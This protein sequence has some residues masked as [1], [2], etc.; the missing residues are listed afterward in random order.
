M[1][2]PFSFVRTTLTRLVVLVPA[3]VL[4]TAC[5]D[6]QVADAN[7]PDDHQESIVN[8]F[9]GP[10]VTGAVTAQDGTTLRVE[11]IAITLT[12]AT[13]F[14]DG[15][16]AIA[17]VQVGDWVEVEVRQVE[18]GLEAQEVAGNISDRVAEIEAEVEARSETQVTL[19]GVALSVTDET[20]FYAPFASL[21]D[22][23]VGDTVEVE[24]RRTDAGAIATE[25]EPYG[26]N[27]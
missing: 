1:T 18:S 21:S 26:N 24:F 6:S 20:D 4:L 12:D 3:L 5:E 22:V 15:L 2:T 13:R 14:E 9:D 27:D 17:G 25:I 10:E 23:A 16:R 19:L 8:A 7:D 11:G